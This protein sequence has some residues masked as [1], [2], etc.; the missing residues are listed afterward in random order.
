MKLDNLF[1]VALG[2][3]VYASSSTAATEGKTVGNVDTGFYGLASAGPGKAGS[4]TDNGWKL[5]LGYDW[6]KYF[7]TEISYNDLVDLRDRTNGACA[8]G[9]TCVD[10]TVKASGYNVAAIGKLPLTESI[11]GLIG[12]SYGSYKLNKV[13][14]F[15]GVGGAST[16]TLDTSATAPMGLL[17][18]QVDLDTRSS[19]R[20]TYEE[21]RVKFFDPSLGYAKAQTLTMAQIGMVVRF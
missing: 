19:L 7:S 20:F 12:V 21:G 18:V 2:L 11:H 4:S 3:A 9:A 17:G 10:T 13:R 5:G 14:Q 15:S 1:I 8:A 16:S 6:N